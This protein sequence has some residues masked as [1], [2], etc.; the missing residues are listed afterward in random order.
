MPGND[1]FYSRNHQRTPPSVKFKSKEKYEPKI[2]LYIAISERGISKPYLVPSGMAVNRHVYIKNCLK[3]IL[4]PFVKQYHA[5]NNYVF[6]SDKAPS[7]YAK[8]TLNYL[9]AQNIP[10]VPKNRNPTSL[11]QCRPIED[12]FGQLSA[13]VYARGWK[14]RNLAQL[15]ARLKKCFKEFDFEPVRRSC[16]HVRRNLRICHREGPYKVAH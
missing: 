6:W 16:E 5:D 4:V 2:M 7:H 8:D 15:S 3:N 12:F 9:R 13:K 11:P 10:F 14:A 1:R